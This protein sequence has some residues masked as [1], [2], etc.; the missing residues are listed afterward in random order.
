[1]KLNLSEN[2]KR[3]RKKHEIT[4]E[5]L[6]G[7]IGVSFQA[8]SKWE[9]DEGYPDITLLPVIASFY[10][11]TLDE[12]MGMNEI[13]NQ[14]KRDQFIQTAHEFASCG[15]RSDCIST[16]KEGLHYFPNDFCIML[17]LATYL[18]GFGET[19][20]ERKM[21]C[22][23]AVKLCQ[24]ILDFST[25]NRIRNKAQSCMCYALYRNGEKEKA[26]KIA[27]D[28]PT[29]Y[30]S[31]E[32]AL[33]NFLHGEERIE[34]CQQTIQK[35]HWLFWWLITRM[36]FEDYYADT[37]K[38]QLLQKAIAFY[39]IVYEKEDY[40][41]GHLR[42][43]DAY[44]DIA[45]LLLK[46]R[47]TDEAISNL[48]KCVQHCISF[49]T[50]PD[51]AKHESLLVNTLEYR[52]QNTDRATENNCCRNVLNSILRDLESSDSLYRQCEEKNAYKQII[53]K[54]KHFAN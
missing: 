35:L 1:M 31:A 51:T 47:K 28:L 54:L 50:L 41:F 20:E 10:N 13:Q 27:E 7:F 15:N 16:L 17:D 33:P 37:E 34:F 4:Q 46:Q 36:N 18:D 42:I 25:D 26:I 6:A 49:D 2:L 9:R 3:L 24:R 21:N 48:D 43:A 11:V 8:V 5:E 14:E 45:V 53:K 23:E 12:L 19:N 39:E 32:A 29:I 22:N 44:E 30:A 38:I 40:H 52:K